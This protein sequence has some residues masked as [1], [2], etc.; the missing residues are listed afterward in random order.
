M[1]RLLHFRC[2]KGKLKSH[3]KSKQNILADSRQGTR[4][5]KWAANCQHSADS[6]IERIPTTGISQ[7]NALG[8]QEN[9][10]QLRV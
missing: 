8:Q 5:V 4:N 1:A 6:Q 10:K 7:T 9:I 3:V 2:S